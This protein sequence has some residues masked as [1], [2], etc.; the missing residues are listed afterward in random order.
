[1]KSSIDLS[2]IIVNYRAIECLQ[3]CIDA[4]APAAGKY[5]FEII[6]VDNN[7]DDGSVPF[8]REKFPHIHLITNDENLGYSKACN[9]GIKEASARFLCFLNPDLFLEVLALE[10]LLDFLSENPEV[11]AVS[12]KFFNCDGSLQP[13]CRNFLKNRY[14]VMKHLVPWKYLPSDWSTWCAIEYWDHSTI[15][16]VD[17]FCGAC[18]VVPRHVVEHVGL[19][20]EDFWSFHEDTDWLQRVHECGYQVVFFPDS[21]GIHVG[22]H[23]MQQLF[24]DRKILYEYLA[25]HQFIKKYYGRT[26]L[27]I[28]R[29]L[30]S[31]LLI[32]RRIGMVVNFS[33]P[34]QNSD[35][36]IIDDCIALQLNFLHPSKLPQY[37]DYT[38]KNEDK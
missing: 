5:S 7:S 21:T 18:M 4:I 16:A 38:G 30:F 37:A 20:D 27:I 22:G 25:K 1:M 24:Q 26:A 33:S 12:P 3:K 23:S 36:A 35:T 14:L 10:K 13:V 19:K 28:H 15:R 17:W 11:G 6:I 32:I 9:Q 8:I 2:I 31:V 34:A 29:I